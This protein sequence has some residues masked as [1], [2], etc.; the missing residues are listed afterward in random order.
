[1]QSFN[2]RRRDMGSLALGAIVLLKPLPLL[3]AD[4]DIHFAAELSPDEETTPIDSP[5]SGHADVWLERAT[6][7][8]TWRI[9]YQK[10][11]TPPTAIGI[12][13]PALPSFN[14][15]LQVDLEGHGLASPV[16]GSTVL[17]DG[18]FQY[19]I[20]SKMFVNILTRGHPTGELRGQLE[21]K[22][23]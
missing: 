13:G 19:L 14:A 17:N 18:Q 7:K 4:D 9:V 23:T 11:L 20:T 15:G 16:T 5:A 22:R 12:Y 10:L 6:L 8:I 2:I 21:R 1:M 3:A